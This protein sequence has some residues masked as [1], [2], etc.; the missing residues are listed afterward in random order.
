MLMRIVIKLNMIKLI[1]SL[2]CVGCS[3]IPSQDNTFLDEEVS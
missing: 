1:S 3:Q 2:K